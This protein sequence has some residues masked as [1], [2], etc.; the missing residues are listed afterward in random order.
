MEGIYEM[1]NKKIILF[2]INL[3]LSIFTAFLTFLLAIGTTILYLLMLMRVVG[4][5]PNC[6]VN[7]FSFL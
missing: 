5:S 7:S 6:G 3:V 1:D 2:T 4:S